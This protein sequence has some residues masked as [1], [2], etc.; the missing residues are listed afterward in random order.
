MHEEQT[1]LI[2]DFGGGTL[3]VSIVKVGHNKLQTLSIDGDQFLGGQDIDNA[4]VDLFV[5]NFE[6]TVRNTEEEDSD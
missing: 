1:Q 2:Y 4:V 5:D 6:R 3:D